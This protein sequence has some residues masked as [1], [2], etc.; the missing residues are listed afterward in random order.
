M[1]HGGRL[2]VNPV[3]RAVYSNVG[4]DLKPTRRAQSS[5]HP[6]P[7]TLS[8]SDGQAALSGDLCG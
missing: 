8:N 7:I 3:E 2:A 4:R 5:D 1:V 6:I